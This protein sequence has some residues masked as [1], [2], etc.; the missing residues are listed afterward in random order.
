MTAK[1]DGFIAEIRS[2][3]EFVTAAASDTRWSD[4]L[5]DIERGLNFLDRKADSD[6]AV[7]E[8]FDEILIVI[9]RGDL[10]LKQ[11]LLEMGKLL[12]KVRDVDGTR[13]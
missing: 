11:R 13:H 8:V 2:R 6:P 5:D 9:G 1:I 12:T 7:I 3:P 10:S 4:H